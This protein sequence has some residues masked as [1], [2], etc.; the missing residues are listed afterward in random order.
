MNVLGITLDLYS[1]SLSW[2]TVWVS[3]SDSSSRNPQ[4]N[5]SHCELLKYDQNCQYEELL[6]SNMQF[7]HQ[8]Q[9]VPSSFFSELALEKAVGCCRDNKS[10]RIQ[11]RWHQLCEASCGPE[12]SSPSCGAALGSGVAPGS[13][14][15]CLAWGFCLCS[16]TAPAMPRA[17][18]TAELL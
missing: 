16:D 17:N 5:V 1:C 3:V 13:T 14:E 8:A 11:S 10:W 6:E 7:K 18:S 12:G 4:F 15:L 9:S 2:S